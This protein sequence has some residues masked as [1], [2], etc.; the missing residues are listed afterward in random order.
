MASVLVK[1]AQDMGVGKCRALVFAVYFDDD[2]DDNNNNNNN[3]KSK[4]HLQFV[5]IL[6]KLELPYIL[7]A[8]FFG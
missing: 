3:N 1:L 6:P 7:V 5:A 2:D 8:V 4:T